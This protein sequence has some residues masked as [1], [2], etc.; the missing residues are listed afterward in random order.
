MFLIVTNF[1]FHLLFALIY[2]QNSC[3]ISARHFSSF[4]LDYICL[5]I[6]EKQSDAA[7]LRTCLPKHS[8][9]N[10]EILLN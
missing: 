2:K 8:Q 10:S 1:R 6:K 9:E 4:Y 3:F 7:K 5:S